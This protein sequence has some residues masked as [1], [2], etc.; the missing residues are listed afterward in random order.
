MGRPYSRQNDSAPSASANLDERRRAPWLQSSYSDPVWTVTDTHD[1]NR[2]G[3]IDFRYRLADGRLLAEVDRL[4]ATVKEYA[5]WVRDP[6]YSRIDSALTHVVTV[7]C[8]MHFAHALGLRK[9]PSFAHLQPYDIEQ[10]VEECR[11]GF[12]A[13]V[14]ASERLEVYLD[15]L[16]AENDL[17]PKPYGGLPRYIS[18]LGKKGSYIHSKQILEACNLPSSVFA[19]PRVAALLARAAKANGLSPRSRVLNDL[20]EASNVTYQA[21]Q[22]WLDPLEQLYAMRRRIEAEAITFK[23]FPR[24]AGRVAAVKGIGTSRTP[25]PPPRLALYLLEHAVRWIFDKGLALTA[26][27]SDRK[28]VVRMATACWIA[29]AAFSARRDEEIDDLRVGCLRGDNTSGWWLHV[30]IEKTLQRKEWIPVPHLVARAV[31]MLLSISRAARLE[32]HSDRLFQWLSPDGGCI[33]LDVG[34]HIDDFATAVR[35]PLYEARGKPAVAWHWHPHQFRRFF[36]VLYFYRF[37]GGSIEVL[38]HHLRHFSL[39]MTKHYITE[40]AEVAALWT[41]TEWDYMGHVARSIVSGERS[42]SGS[43]G[44]RLKKTAKRLI[45]VF[46]RKLQVATPERVGAS[47][48]LIM[49]RQGMVLTPKPWVT[50]SCPR[51]KEA[52]AK[53]GCRRQ[54]PSDASAVGPDFAYAGPSVCSSCPHAVIEGARKP[55]V[56]AEVQHLETAAASKARAGTIFG[57]LEDARVVELRDARYEGARPLGGVALDGE[58]LL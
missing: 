56:D 32:S 12:D 58:E 35:V 52:A 21:L 4:Y 10:L 50:C 2:T 17:D 29:I 41:D 36:A 47:L 14:H 20:P 23:P 3:V 5:W 11:Y 26:V 16:A 46:R 57:A 55:F 45:D 49:Q 48:T 15:Q 37:E 54:R 33:R 28:A 25:T 6:R 19:Q 44:E 39:E 13:V 31:E 38:S 7:R 22:R 34:C 8:M 27:S 30:Y 18:P 42:I 51:T 40:D 53:A 9:L 24:G 1:P 43:A